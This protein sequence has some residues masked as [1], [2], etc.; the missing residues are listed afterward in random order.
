MVV[1]HVLFKDSMRVYGIVHFTV[2]CLLTKPF[3]KSEAK[4]DLVMI[5][6]LL[7]FKCKLLCYYANLALVSITTR[8]PSASFQTRTWLYITV[9]WPIVDA[10]EKE[11]VLSSPRPL[12]GHTRQL[13]FLSRLLKYFMALSILKQS[14]LV[15]GLK[16]A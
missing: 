14:C 16:T 1:L 15:E 12:R 3:K 9:K 6:T 10:K 2:A 11:N 5:Q 7:L 8:S 13:H 4:G